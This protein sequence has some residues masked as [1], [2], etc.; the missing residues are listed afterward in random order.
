MKTSNI[1]ITMTNHIYHIRDVTPWI[2]VRGYQLSGEHNAFIFNLFCNL[3]KKEDSKLLWTSGGFEENHAFL[4]FFHV[5]Y[6]N[7]A[8][9]TKI[10]IEKLT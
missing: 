4:F 1:A 6:E 5:E 10:K 7:V 9:H 2:L 3:K 8:I